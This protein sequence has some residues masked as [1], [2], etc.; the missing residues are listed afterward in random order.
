MYF[1]SRATSKHA[2]TKKKIIYWDRVISLATCLILI[3][4]V[5]LQKNGRLAGKTTE[6]IQQSFFSTDEKNKNTASDTLQR[7]SDGTIIVHTQPLAPK[8]IGFGGP[9][10]LNIYIKNGVIDH[11]EAEPNAETP[12][13]FNN[14]KQG[15]IPHYEGKTIEEALAQ[16]VDAVTGATYSSMAIIE[17]TKRGLTFAQSNIKEQPVIGTNKATT[18]TGNI[19]QI[20]IG[21][22]VVL[23]GA[24]MPL[25]SKNKLYRI[26]QLII[27]VAVLGVWCGTF[28]S[29][30]LLVNFVSNGVNIA[31]ML[32][33]VLMLIVALAYPLFG[34]SRHYC[35][36]IC[37][38]G[39]AQE[40]LWRFSPLKR[41]TSKTLQ[42]VL[43]LIRW[44]IWTVL[45][46]LMVS[47]IWM[48]WMDYEL[49]SIFLF[50][51][52]SWVVIA[53]SALFALLSL[54]T[55]RPYCKYLC[56][57]GCLLQAAENKKMSALM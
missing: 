16:D 52:A 8:V 9:T 6:E 25:I 24:V 19:W 48:E 35:M 1:K 33:A 34:Q 3:A 40:L 7:Q 15:I 18:P 31:A 56:P 22:S 38:L 43:S 23:L 11:I 27:N 32:V 46:I 4:T 41:K 21:C 51:Q 20:I 54:F 53:L 30:S 39:S 28:I 10:P 26:I 37:P 44:I 13:F 55:Q 57:T 2:M 42:A 50:Q 36:W 29:Y 47:G 17:N 49:F 5:A 45:M 12:D 14:A